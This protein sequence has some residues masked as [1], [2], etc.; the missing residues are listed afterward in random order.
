MYLQKENKHIYLENKKKYFFMASG[1]GS[2]YVSQMYTVYCTLHI[3]QIRRSASASVPK[4]HGSGT[5]AETISISSRVIHKA[6]FVV[7]DCMLKKR[8][9]SLPM[10]LKVLIVRQ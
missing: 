3:V 5:L 9:V 8:Q 1:A 2:G 10:P 4:C 7:G 6:Q